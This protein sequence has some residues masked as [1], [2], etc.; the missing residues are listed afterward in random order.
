ML[1]QFIMAAAVR[2]KQSRGTAAP[3]L[4]MPGDSLLSVTA[5]ET[6]VTT[7]SPWG[8]PLHHPQPLQSLR[9]LQHSLSLCTL[10]L[11][12]QSSEVSSLCTDLFRISLHPLVLLH[13]VGA[14]TSSAPPRFPPTSP[15]SKLQHSSKSTPGASGS[16]WVVTSS[17]CSKFH[18]VFIPSW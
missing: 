10:L 3:T 18:A 1:A 5:A 15:Y 2:K 16:F 4:A 8:S 9:H 6:L 11:T 13:Q 12:H 17:G 14:P 7:A